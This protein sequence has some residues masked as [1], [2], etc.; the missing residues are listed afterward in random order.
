MGW[1]QSSRFPA[2]EFLL[3]TKRGEA[4]ARSGLHGCAS[5]KVELVLL[6]PLRHLDLAAISAVSLVVNGSKQLSHSCIYFHTSV[7]LSHVCNDVTYCN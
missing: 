3:L 5:R 1:S 6:L 2:A 4:V 7:L